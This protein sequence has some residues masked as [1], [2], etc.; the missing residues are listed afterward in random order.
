M[1]LGFEGAVGVAGEAPAAFVA[2]HVVAAT[3]QRTVVFVGRA[4]VFPPDEM[5]GVA[6][7]RR[8]FIA[9]EHTPAVA[10]HQRFA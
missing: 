7:L 9:G 8:P 10:E 2:E 5:M 1:G 4:L 3:Q 6:P